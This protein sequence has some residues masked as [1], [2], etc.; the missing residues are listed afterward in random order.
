[1]KANTRQ[2]S[3][4]C[5]HLDMYQYKLPT[6]VC[7]DEVEALSDEHVYIGRG[8]S[9]RRLPASKWANPFR[10]GS[11][12]RAA[13][14]HLFEQHLLDSKGL[15][16]D[17]TEL[18]GKVLV[19]HCKAE[20]QC[21]ADILIKAAAHRFHDIQFVACV[22]VPVGS[23]NIESVA[24]PVSCV[25]VFAG[26]AGI[27]EALVAAGLPTLAIDWHGNKH[28]PKVPV[29]Q[30]DLTSSDG[31]ARL[32]DI[33]AR[34]SVKFVWF[35]PPCGTFSR[36]RE[37]PVPRRSVEQ[38]APQPKPLRDEVFPLGFP[39]LGRCDSIKVA[40]GNILARTTAEQA[41]ALMTRGALFAIENPENSWIW[42]HPAMADLLAAS[43]V[44]TVKF[45]NCMFGGRRNKGTTL[46]TNMPEM[47]NMNKLCD[48]GHEHAPW[49]LAFS[50]QRAFATADECE[51][52]DILCSEVARLV[53]AAT[54]D[55]HARAE[56]NAPQT[57][58]QVDDLPSGTKPAWATGKQTRKRLSYD[59]VQEYKAI[60]TI[61]E[62]PELSPGVTLAKPLK[63]AD[64]K[65][66]PKGSKCLRAPD[67]QGD[68]GGVRVGV[69]WTESEFVQMAMSA[70]HP[71]DELPH[72][73]DDVARAIF[74][75]AT[76]GAK[77]VG[78]RCKLECL[79]WANTA[80]SLTAAEAALHQAMPPEVAKVLE[81]K[82]L[83]TFR[84]MLKE[85]SYADRELA[86]DLATGFRITGDLGVS[87]AFEKRP[88]VVEG[89][90][91][92]WLWG[93]AFEVR[94]AL[95]AS[96]K[97][98][99]RQDPLIQEAVERATAEEVRLG[100]A[101]GPWTA[102]ELGQQLGPRW[103]PSRRFGIQQGTKVRAIDDFSESFVNE[104]I[105]V[106]EKISLGGVDGLANIVKLW[107]HVLKADAGDIKI[108]LNSGEILYGKLHEDFKGEGGKLMGRCF[109]LKA[110]YKQCAV[111]PA[112]AAVA[113]FA[114][115]SSEVEGGVA[116]Y[117]AHAL[118]FGSGASVVGFNRAA[119]GLRAC[120]NRCFSIPVDNFFDDYPVV[121]PAAVATTLGL[122]FKKCAE[123]TGW[124]LRDGD[125]D[126][127]FAST[128]EVLGVVFDLKAVTTEGTLVVKN[129]EA[130]TKALSEQLTSA[131]TADRLSAAEAAQLAG[132]LQFASAQVFGRCGTAILWNIR[133][134]AEAKGGT[135]P[136][137]H[138]LRMALLW[139]RRFL[140]TA[141]PRVV[142][143][144]PGGPPLLLFTDGFCEGEGSEVVAGIGAVLLD[145][146]D[147]FAEAFGAWIPPH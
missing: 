119:A 142:A 129:T 55:A 134:R 104:C 123:I 75:V 21:H 10:V 115:G 16:Q 18:S 43:G 63:L 15:L 116:F 61:P 74:R 111:H 101:S 133:R 69:H 48:G 35:A 109:D 79:R 141:R 31:A 29:R 42:K 3:A 4:S 90:A 34:P 25:E 108:V 146:A 8:D 45:H 84:E 71:F 60:L 92:S 64:G 130:R 2:T 65:V 36:A 24:P 46:A 91:V 23:T 78:E 53:V 128:F 97:E 62:G 138:N 70:K 121:A 6:K 7:L 30:I 76:E 47:Q 72:V 22:K 98:G 57:P 56:A 140:G 12:G 40:K 88:V 110:A 28:K 77:R 54:T 126:K 144:A 27:A 100:W 81:G 5:E 20:Q 44:F 37:V 96:L 32:E 80:A 82:N 132:R 127:D 93:Q 33:I 17:L 50:R 19:C 89:K 112:D 87:E 118:P 113:V 49:G 73:H 41:G 14:V 58:H 94:A 86:G 51:Y 103:V 1:V 102:Q 136:L 105:T 66:V 124:V 106:R 99:R 139:W 85:V 83:L 125:K 68:S 11:G 120:M 59:V 67:L 135:G 107:H 143:L 52:P 38:G 9:R 117:R 145:P 147:G 39:G 137:D 114:H 131:L 26:S 122:T 13:A 95:V